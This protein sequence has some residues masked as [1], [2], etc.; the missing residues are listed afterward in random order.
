MT[1]TYIYSLM[2]DADPNQFK[3]KKS[4]AEDENAEVA[5]GNVRNQTSRLASNRM[6][7]HPCQHAKR[8]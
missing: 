7:D 4:L 6:R 5:Y 8:R 1:I 3:E 2:T